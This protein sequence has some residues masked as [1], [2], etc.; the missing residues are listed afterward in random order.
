MGLGFMVSK[1]GAPLLVGHTGSQAGFTS[2]VYVNPRTAMAIIAAFNTAGR[3]PSFKTLKS[4][5][6]A[7]LLRED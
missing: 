7:L 4:S 5:A 1:P 2:F 3:L 6:R